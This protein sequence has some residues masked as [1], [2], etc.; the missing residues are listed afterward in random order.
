MIFVFLL[1]LETMIL[2]C[3]SAVNDSKAT[4]IRNEIKTDG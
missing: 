1:Y 4:T 2:S 3:N